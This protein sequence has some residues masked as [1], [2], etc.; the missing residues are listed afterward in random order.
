[1]R[2]SAKRLAGRRVGP[3]SAVRAGA[4]LIAAAA[5]ILGASCASVNRTTVK[6]SKADTARYLAAG[7][8]GKAIEAQKALRRADPDNKRIL[9]GYV[10]TL[11]TIKKA[12]DA[13]RGR[14]GYAEA[15]AGYGALVDGW[16]PDPALAAALS[17]GK[18]DVEAGRRSCLVAVTNEQAK[19][20]LDSG[21]REGALA[22]WCK[23]IAAEP[24][25]KGLKGPYAAAVVA[26]KTA[27]D[28]ALAEQDQTAAGKSYALL[29]KHAGTF[30]G[31]EGLGKHRAELTA[32]RL[33]VAVKACS[34]GLMDR[35]LAAYRKGELETA[36]GI[37]R[38]ALAFD[39]ENAEIGKAVETA[40]AQLGKVK[41]LD[42]G[43]RG[44]QTPSPQ[45]YS[46]R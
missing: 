18:K 36:I 38:G 8:Y 7:E 40:T 21:D 42:I 14:A 44:G 6:D 19:R 2:T 9:A 23:A 27:A 5:V 3:R 32:E 30:A 29:R 46:T 28:R 25:E 17:F 4:G 20:M 26:I 1:M 24:G 35:G 41:K 39:P 45:K 37:W 34:R 11:E 33:A 43:G 12:A 16:D 22:V 13:A 15:A 10:Q 31:L